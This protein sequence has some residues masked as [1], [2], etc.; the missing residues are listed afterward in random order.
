MTRI[1]VIDDDASVRSVL[2]RMLEGEGYEVAEAAS[3]DEGLAYCE[4]G[5]P[6]VVVTDLFMPG[7]GGL[8]VIRRIAVTYPGTR[9]IAATGCAVASLVDLP[10]LVTGQGASDILTKPVDMDDLLEA[11]RRAPS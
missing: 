1:L 8:D 6:D 3:G 10:A 2:R 7:T 9:T 5:F 4:W 11:I